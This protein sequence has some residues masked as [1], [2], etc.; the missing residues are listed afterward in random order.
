MVVFVLC[1]ISFKVEARKSLSLSETMQKFDEGIVQ[2]DAERERLGRLYSSDC[3]E[4]ILRNIERSGFDIEFNIF[5]G[6][7]D[8]E[9]HP[10]VSVDYL[11]RL[12]LIPEFQRCGFYINP[13]NRNQLIYDDGVKVNFVRSSIRKNSADGSQSNP[14]YDVEISQEAAKRFLQSLRKSNSL[15]IYLGHSRYGRGI[16][17]FSRK[18]GFKN[19]IPFKQIISEMQV[20]EG[21]PP[22][23]GTAIISCDSGRHSRVNNA[24]LPFLFYTKEGVFKAKDTVSEFFEALESLANNRTSSSSTVRSMSNGRLYSR[25]SSISSKLP[26]KIDWGF[27]GRE[28]LGP[29]S[30]VPPESLEVAEGR[31]NQGCWGF[32][33]SRRT[34]KEVI[35]EGVLGIGETGWGELFVPEIVDSLR[36]EKLNWEDNSNDP[37]NTYLLAR[38]YL[39]VGDLVDVLIELP[40]V[41]HMLHQQQAKPILISAIFSNP[42]SVRILDLAIESLTNFQRAYSL[43]AFNYFARN[44]KSYGAQQFDQDLDSARKWSGRVS[45]PKIKKYFIGIEPYLVEL[46]FDDS[47]QNFQKLYEEEFKAR[48][49]SQYTLMASRPSIR[50]SE[51]Y[52]RSASPLKPEARIQ[53]RF[54]DGGVYFAS[55]GQKGIKLVSE[56]GRRSWNFP[57]DDEQALNKVCESEA[58]I[59]QELVAGLKREFA[60]DPKLKSR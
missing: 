45:L 33:K 13:E 9:E 60:N 55:G 42:V 52:K 20:Q 8:S 48:T 36:G 4:P 51:L 53:L 12:N 29:D 5:L 21:V 16:D 3:P 19:V 54:S 1:L 46:S 27:V 30:I 15:N 39:V 22:N 10:L 17:F 26:I 31:L 58:R 14:N 18:N 34:F 38:K 50:A 25:A 40:I 24:D 41:L 44:Y 59:C 57:V 43:R 28:I 6:F 2:I 11:I 23:L 37:I 32:C 49:F 56:D 47:D 7:F 35:Y